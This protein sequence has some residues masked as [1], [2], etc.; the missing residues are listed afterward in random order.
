MR[1]DSSFVRWLL[2]MALLVASCGG[3]KPIQSGPHVTPP[4]AAGDV[5]APPDALDDHDAAAEPS[6]PG[7]V[8]MRRLSDVE[9]VNTIQDLFGLTGLEGAL[10]ASV[11]APEGTVDGFDDL[12]GFTGVGAQRFE[13]YFATA[14]YVVE[15]VFADAQARTR[16]L[17]CIPATDER[18]CI[19]SIIDLLGKRAWRRPLTSDEVEGLADLVGARR[20]AG[21]DFET[22]IESMVVAMLTS[23]SFLFRIELDPETA[24]T[25]PHLLT[26]FEIAS[27]LSYLLWSTMPDD[28]LFALAVMGALHDPLKLTAEVTRMLADPRARGFER[29]FLGQWLGFRELYGPTLARAAAPD[30]MADVQLSMAEEARLFVD[31]LLKEDA[32]L[33]ELLTRKVHFVDMSLTALYGYLGFG[34]TTGSDFVRM[35]PKNDQRGGYLGFVAPLTLSSRST[36]TS[37]T[38]RGAWVLDRFLCLTVPDGPS[39]IHWGPV[40][41][42]ATPRERS[43]AIQQMPS[44]GPCHRLADRVGLALE[45]YD[46]LGVYRERYP[47]PSANL[48]PIDTNGV[49]PPEIPFNDVI[50]LEDVLAADARFYRCAVRKALTYAV[51]RRFDETDAARIE[52]IEGAW[53]QAGHTLRAL[54]TAVVVDDTFRYHRPE[55]P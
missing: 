42:G 43:A 5:A 38:T 44:C 25:A 32:D 24:G 52:A 35:V 3:R 2:G 55:A 11:A 4:D 53:K 17:V 54:V 41:P 37:P 22:A 14:V 46:E 16:V 8:R 9:Y 6:D 20:A 19:R 7:V 49:L 47:D 40:P 26:G 29:D 31:E 51:G 12:A 23:E 21:D 50:G 34:G 36:G 39:D 27:R 30:S 28:R 1:F 15:T 48:H 10:L 13:R 45:R 33:S 18:P